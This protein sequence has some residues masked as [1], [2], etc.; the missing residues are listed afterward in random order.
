MMV[1]NNRTQTYLVLGFALGFP[2]FATWLYF[3]VLAQSHWVQILYG[4]S[5]FIQFS[6][7]LAWILWVQKRKLLLSKPSG[8]GAWIGM[9]SGLLVVVILGLAYFGYLKG[10]SYLAATPLLLREK[11]TSFGINTPV[12]Y[13]SFA[14]FLSLVHSYLEEYYWRWFLFGELRNII[15]IPWAI[16]VSSLGFMAHHIIV[17]N[18]F[19]PPELFWNVT[20]LFSL[21]VG[22]G[23]AFWAW[24]YQKSGSLLGPWLSH[25]IVDLGIMAIGWYIIMGDPVQLKSN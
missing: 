7:P 5:K 21:C 9:G 24:L 2:T 12:S 25:L 20:L 22:L 15:G 1:K 3:E 13:W 16:I 10:S 14:I 6:L 19:L 8:Q 23:G 11:L 17:I 4:A 18:A